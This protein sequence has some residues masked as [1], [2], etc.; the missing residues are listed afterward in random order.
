MHVCTYTQGKQFINRVPGI[1]TQSTQQEL[2]YTLVLNDEPKAELV[3]LNSWNLV[4]SIV[5]PAAT[6]VCWHLPGRA[7]S[8]QARQPESRPIG[9]S[10]PAQ[11]ESPCPHPHIDRKRP[12][13]N[14]RT[15]AVGRHGIASRPPL[16]TA[17]HSPHRIQA[18]D[19]R[20]AARNHAMDPL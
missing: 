19:C 11:R 20:G 16:M 4:K 8:R 14:R 7:L 18:N 5:M 15:A 3:T 12:S 10:I 9:V 17:W 13:R 2:I 6:Y 1:C